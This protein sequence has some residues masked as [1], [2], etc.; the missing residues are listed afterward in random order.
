MN[1][2]P[3]ESH[4]EQLLEQIPPEPGPRLD[5]RL[6]NAPWTPGATARR[7]IFALATTGFLTLALLAAFTPQGLAFAQ[8]ILRFFV[9]ADSEI[10]LAPTLVPVIVGMPENPEPVPSLQPAERFP[11]QE[12][13]GSLTFPTCSTEEIRALVS[14]PVKELATLPPDWEFIG[15]TGGPERITI[16]YRNPA[17]TLELSQG[18]SGASQEFVWPVGSVASVDIVSVGNITGEYVQGAWTDSG[19][20]TGATTWDAS[21]PQRVLRWETGNIRYTLRFL[22]GK[23]DKGLEPDKALL[24]NLAA[25]LGKVSPF[26][27][28]PRP[29]P[30]TDTNVVA[31]QAGFPVTLP[32]WLPERF[33]LVN[34]DFVPS[35]NTVCQYYAHPGSENFA[36]LVIIE[37]TRLLS[38]QDILLPPQFYSGVQ[39]DIPVYTETVPLAGAKNGQALYASNGL[40]I[41]TIC[42]NQNLTSNHALLWQSN[43][44]NYIISAML[45]AYDGRS[46]LTRLEMRRVAES[47]TGAL[48]VPVD[49]LDPEHLVSTAD[50]QALASFDIKTPR[51]MPADMHFAYAVYR[52]PGASTMPVSMQNG[53]EEVVLVYLGT[54]FDNIE[55]RHSFLFF[56]NT[57]SPNTLVEMALGGGEWVTVNGLP[58]VYSQTCWNETAEDADATCELSLSWLDEKN[59]RFDLIAYLPGALKKETFISIAESLR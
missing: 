55:R 57:I 4:V 22:P 47:L 25:Q 23:S 13:C 3:D 43:G 45:N 14:F 10:Q 24:V 58:A 53:G 31:E 7:R 59:I 27:L 56:Q 44:H 46:F 9:R 50:A 8:N 35:Q 48:I 20:N 17:G 21:I 2:M 39:I 16:V 37:S 38:L 1:P 32:G 49:T 34:A 29:T 40:N 41:N 42:G 36:N 26:A 52:G 19:E 5:H 6:S 51:R 28:S 33:S 18:L 54:T 12:T 11:F 30:G 15:A